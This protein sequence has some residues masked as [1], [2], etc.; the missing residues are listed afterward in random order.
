MSDH[1][2]PWFRWVEPV[3]EHTVEAFWCE[4]L[5]PVTGGDKSLYRAYVADDITQTLTINTITLDS[6]NFQITVTFAESI[7][8]AVR[9]FLEATGV[10]D[11]FGNAVDMHKKEFGNGPDLLFTNLRITPRDVED[12]SSPVE[13]IYDVGN[14][15]NYD[16]TPFTVSL[17][18]QTV[19]GEIL[20]DHFLANVQH[21]ALSAGEELHH[22]TMILLPQAALQ[23]NR[24]IARI[25]DEGNVAE[26]NEVNNEK[27]IPFTTL[28]PRIISILDTP[29]DGGGWVNITFNRSLYDNSSTTCPIPEYEIYR[30][31]PFAPQSAVSDYI[32]ATERLSRMAEIQSSVAPNSGIVSASA[33]YFL[34]DWTLVETVPATFQ[35]EYSSTVPTSGI[36]SGGNV[37]STYFIRAK[38]PCTSDLY[39]YS[40]PDSGFSYDNAV[41]PA[42]DLDCFL[43]SIEGKSVKLIWQ[44]SKMEGEG[45]FVVTRSSEGSDFI[46]VDVEIVETSERAYC[47]FDSGVE[48]GKD[49]SY[50]VRLV[51]ETGSYLLFETEP[52]RTPAIKLTLYQN[53][54]N[55]FNPSTE[56]RYYLPT[57]GKVTL[58]IFDVAG[59]RIKT[60]VNGTQPAG[61]YSVDWTGRDNNGSRVASGVYF[62]R[63]RTGKEMLTRKMVLMR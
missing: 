6:D 32:L 8:Y 20:E 44:F 41:G 59:R 31:N 1:Y 56:V 33:T 27:E 30:K 35:N 11:E 57:A 17:W 58:D 49:Y 26:R 63:L 55:P 60:L 61:K 19:D 21:P 28:I 52:I 3:S 40:C 43:A 14:E 42:Y 34:D 4:R 24:I 36:L 9:Y 37:W 51:T 23:N 10:T 48:P 25:D 5:N 50:R 53:C 12:G 7:E 13:I 46:K 47:F 22:E 45:K 2:P 62:Y 38:D 29:G 54:P 39:Y 18:M 16:A 15:G